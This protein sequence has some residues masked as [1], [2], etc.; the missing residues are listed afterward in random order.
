VS[1]VDVASAA[2]RT[3]EAASAARASSLAAEVAS[4]SL[5]DALFEG[6]VTFAGKVSNGRAGGSV[7]YI[8]RPAVARGAEDVLRAGVEA[9][10][11]MLKAGGG[12][13][14]AAIFRK[15]AESVEDLSINA[16]SQTR[17]QAVRGY[18][19]GSWQNQK[20]AL[21]IETK[22]FD[23]KAFT[24]RYELYL[25]RKVK[26]RPTKASKNIDPDAVGGVFIHELVHTLDYISE[27][28]LG[29]DL[30]LRNKIE[31][32]GIFARVKEIHKG[33]DKG[34]PEHSDWSY[35]TTQ[36]SEALPEIS[37]MY[38]QGPSTRTGTA[39]DGAAWREEY[40]D[41]AEWV[42]ENVLNPS[43]VGF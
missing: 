23:V 3:A 1:A 22:E 39:A 37:R 9:A 36:R 17:T 16:T 7:G 32:D 5:A 14:A 25:A 11:K 27:I 21:M 33:F 29:K 24:D 6:T 2:S 40:P 15:L 10:D 4:R 26:A 38:F 13:E 30:M 19:G 8:N 20:K 43:L 34:T 31:A 35:A 41:L 12:D 28:K 18:V 42:K